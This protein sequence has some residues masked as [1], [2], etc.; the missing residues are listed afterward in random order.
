MNE[1]LKEIY[2]VYNRICNAY[3]KNEVLTVKKLRKEHGIQK[4]DM[5][6]FLEFMYTYICLMGDSAIDLY[7]YDS[8]GK[9]YNTEKIQEYVEIEV[10]S[11]KEVDDLAKRVM[12]IMNDNWSIRVEDSIKTYVSKMDSVPVLNVP[13]QD[14]D[15]VNEI[16]KFGNIK[17]ETL[18]MIDKSTSGDFPF[19]KKRE[20]IRAILTNKK[21]RIA[22]NISNK[23]IKEEEK[24]PVG[25]Y[26]DKFLQK[27]YGVFLEENGTVNEID[28]SDIRKVNVSKEEISINRNFDIQ[29]YLTEIQKYKM[30]LRVYEE[31]NVRKK[32]ELLLRDNQLKIEKKEDYDVYSIMVSDEQLYAEKIRQFGRSVIIEE[33]KEIKED[34]IAEIKEIMAL[35]E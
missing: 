32:L 8:N 12:E 16:K 15:I 23:K 6:I 17:V 2:S 26:Y 13:K 22:K 28:I 35:Y 11:P 1:E 19:Q 14:H 24:I 29:D 10:N 25:L 33:P 4:R 20:W 7:I 3:K 27:Y 31:G 30:V 18:K 9:E 34:M 5:K 21:V